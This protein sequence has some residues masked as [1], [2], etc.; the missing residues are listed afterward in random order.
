MRLKTFKKMPKI[1]KSKLIKTIKKS[2][3]IKI[4]LKNF[5]IN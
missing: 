1:I 4:L 5:K 3:N 2:K